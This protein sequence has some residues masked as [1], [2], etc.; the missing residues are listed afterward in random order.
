MVCNFVHKALNSYVR[1]LIVH[2]SRTP[3]TPWTVAHSQKFINHA[4]SPV[5]SLLQQFPQFIV[6]LGPL[7]LI[8]LHLRIALIIPPMSIEVPVTER[9]HPKNSI[10]A[11]VGGYE[12]F[13]K[14]VAVTID[15]AR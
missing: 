11:S 12:R 4:T 13:Q 6:E 8:E 1:L 14:V 15:L 3:R 10:D 7:I 5:Q 2:H 9:E